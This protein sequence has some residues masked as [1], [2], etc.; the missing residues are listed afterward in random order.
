MVC[1]E[2]MQGA[3]SVDGSHGIAFHLEGG[4]L[5]TFQGKGGSTPE[6]LSL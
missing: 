1:S 2:S 5:Y 6:D 4:A 3:F